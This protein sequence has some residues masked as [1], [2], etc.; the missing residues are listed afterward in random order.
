MSS[1]LET[2]LDSR[3]ASDDGRSAFTFVSYAPDREDRVAMT[4]TDLD[5][6]ARAVAVR[7]RRTVPAGGRVAIL[8]PNSLG[9][10]VAFFGCVRAGLIAV[11][12]H[13]PVQAGHA[14]RLSSVIRDCLPAALLTTRS[15]CAAV[16]AFVQQADL[17]V[18]PEI[19]DVD[20]VSPALAESWEP[21]PPA[22]DR[23]AYLQYTSGSTSAPTGVVI[24]QAGLVA[25]MRQA[26]VIYGID[27]R[28]TSVSWLPLFHDMGLATTIGSPLVHGARAVFLEPFSFVHHP[29]RWLRLLGEPDRSYGAAPDFAFD[30]CVER[31]R[32]ADLEGLDLGGVQ[33]IINGAEPIRPRTVEAFEE[34]FARHGLRPQTV[35]P[36]YGLAEA[37]VF[38][39]GSRRLR[40]TSIDLEALTRGVAQEAVDPQ[41]PDSFHRLVA[42]GQPG[43]VT[44]T[45]AGPGVERP[46]ARIVDVETRTVLPSGRVGE[47]W[48]NSAG[49]GRGY[50]NRPDLT[51]ETFGAEL[52][53]AAGVL[54]ERGWLRTGDLGFIHGGELHVAG[55]IKDVIIVDGANHYP[56]D[57]ENT[58]ESAH[59]SVRRG[60]VAAFGVS[61]GDREQ[62]VI[63]A[64]FDT[65]RVGVDEDFES[66]LRGIRTQV[67]TVHDVRVHDIVP[68]R[69]GTVPLTSS[70]K[71]RRSQ[72]RTQYET[73]EPAERIRA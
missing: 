18:A 59:P 6:R 31:C 16:R 22:P 30:Y 49:L 32:E 64:E 21:T 55:R 19:I 26:A 68:V 23:I 61:R 46:L 41:R 45:T 10:V 66:V 67:T 11:P 72:C 47:I 54:P 65:R 71:V 12:V 39:S 50:W 2:L 52:A 42:C 25:N 48:V 3:V 69:S 44:G 35:R 8:A 14:A 20:A 70:G 28:L 4:W 43:T 17:P 40:V 51:R 7:L 63:V 37:T 60:R 73:G 62:V 56:S 27:E 9:Y 1:D 36:S 33:F 13:G 53:D 38:V 24:T 29:S 58:V 57:I 5:R 15:E 34:R